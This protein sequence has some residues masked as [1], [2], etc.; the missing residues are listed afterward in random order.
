MIDNVIG[1]VVDCTT[2]HRGPDGIYTLQKIYLF[3]EAVY[4]ILFSHTV[5]RKFTH[6]CAP[7]C[8]D[9]F[10]MFTVVIIQAVHKRRVSVEEFH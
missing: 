2:I 7:V 4:N 10:S 5:L 3:S 6:L 8:V 9:R 1:D